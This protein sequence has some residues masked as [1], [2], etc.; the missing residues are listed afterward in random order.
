ME[1]DSEPLDILF[2]QLHP[3]SKP[4]GHLVTRCEKE[5]ERCEAGLKCSGVE[6]ITAVGVTVLEHSQ[7]CR[8]LGVLGQESAA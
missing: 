1:V 4:E 3:A 8:R 6:E 7:P 2:A 5:I